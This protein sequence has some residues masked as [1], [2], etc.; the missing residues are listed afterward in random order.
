MEYVI[1]FISGVAL[2]L[3]GVGA[4]AFAQNKRALREEE[5]AKEKARGEFVRMTLFPLYRKLTVLVSINDSDSEGMAK[6]VDQI[7]KRW[8]T[9]EQE[10]IAYYSVADDQIQNYID[11]LFNLMIEAQ[12]YFNYGEDNFFNSDTGQW[13]DCFNQESMKI[14]ESIGPILEDH[15]NK[16]KLRCE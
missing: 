13:L 3:I 4:S 15:K 5:K 6:E 16:N 8:E 2:T 14:I 11:S 7:F 10:L 12:D 9:I 1:T